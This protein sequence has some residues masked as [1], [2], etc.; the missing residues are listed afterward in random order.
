M[1][2]AGPRLNARAKWAAAI[3]L[4][5]LSLVIAVYESSAWWL[6]AYLAFRKTL[7]AT[8]WLLASVSVLDGARAL[9]PRFLRRAHLGSCA[10]L[11]FGVLAVAWAPSAQIQN[12]ASQAHVEHLVSVLRSASDWDRDGSSSFL[13][14]GDCAPFDPEI[15][16]RARE[17]PDNG[18]DDNCRYG[19]AKGIPQSPP[20]KVAAKN[21]SPVNVLLV[22][23]DSLRMD[24]TTP[25]GYSRNTTPHLAELARR[26]TLYKRAYTSGGWTCLALPSMFMGS[27]SRRMPF[28]PLALTWEHDL[29]ELPFEPKLR[30]GDNFRLMVNAPKP[31]S[32]WLLHRTLAERGM[33]TIAVYSWYVR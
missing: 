10:L 33:Q 23:I 8:S 28:R 16:P 2:R 24:H 12:L 4:L 13:G 17:I 32:A 9:A 15:S 20:S 11:G 14:G 26:G 29:L 1:R 31:E 21:P 7:V 25:Y 30:K 18:K 19:D 3:A 6:R 27:Y 5:I 22:T